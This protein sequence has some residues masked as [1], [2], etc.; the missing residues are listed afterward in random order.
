MK[1]IGEMAKGK[2]KFDAA[3]AAAAARDLSKSTQKIPDLFPR[4][5]TVIRATRSMRSGRS[6]TASGRCP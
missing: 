3:K 2:K 6:G 5:A 1:L 4:E